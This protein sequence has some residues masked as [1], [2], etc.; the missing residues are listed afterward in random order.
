MHF[1]PRVS[2]KFHEYQAAVY[3]GHPIFLAAAFITSRAF[4]F[5]RMQTQH[6]GQ[7]FGNFVDIPSLSLRTF[8]RKRLSPN[9]MILLRAW[10][11]ER[12]F[13]PYRGRGYATVISAE[14]NDTTTGGDE[15]V[16]FHCSMVNRIWG[17]VERHFRA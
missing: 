7:L 9:A 1:L 13:R 16:Y 4:P 2:P 12:I 17:T 11:I 3:P 15:R 6:R 10:R 5:G 8:S 14:R